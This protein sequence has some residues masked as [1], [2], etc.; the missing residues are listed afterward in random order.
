MSNA[1]IDYCEM[2]KHDGY[3]AAPKLPKCEKYKKCSNEILQKLIILDGLEP[4]EYEHR[5]QHVEKSPHANFELRRSQERRV[6][7]HFT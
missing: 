7:A 1:E 4:R 5:I 2:E 6:M 3:L